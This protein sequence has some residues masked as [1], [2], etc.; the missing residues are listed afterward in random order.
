MVD[1][2]SSLVSVI[3]PCYNHAHFLGEAIDSALN[4]TYFPVEVIIVDD[5]STDEIAEIIVTRPSIRYLR[6]DNMGLA[7][8]RNT[9]L[10]HST[11]DYVLFLDADDRLLPNAVTTGVHA[12]KARKDCAFVF[13]PF[14]AIGT[15][16]GLS[17]L[18]L[19]QNYD[20]A[21]LL[22]CNFI[23]NPGSVLYNK[24]VFSVV[25]NF[26][27]SNSPAADYD[28]Y[29]RVARQ[30]PI[31][32][33]HHAVVEY[34]KH[35]DNM[36]N[37]ARVMLKATL[38]ALNNQRRHASQFPNLREAYQAGRRNLKNSYG[39]PLIMKTYENLKQ[40]EYLEAAQNAY[41]LMR[42]FPERLFIFATRK[43]R[44][45]TSVLKSVISL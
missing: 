25:G 43:I 39:E 28:L 36:S 24:W 5:G 27:E 6:Q 38:T 41:A 4:Q 30:F 16:N 1:R 45:F 11:G 31:F 20:Y 21:G 15:R 23:G 3:I 19:D 35:G 44:R 34:R 9:G 32:C 13:G 18:P 14:V 33:H 2:P 17:D 7:H 8:A 26:D 10:S 37:D 12:L 22:K 40:G 29:L 42:F